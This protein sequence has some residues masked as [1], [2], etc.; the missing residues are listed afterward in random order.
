MSFVKACGDSNQLPRWGRHRSR[1]APLPSPS[2]PLDPVDAPARAGADP[3]PAH[4]RC[5]KQTPR[6]PADIRAGDLNRPTT[7]T[8]RGADT[9]VWIAPG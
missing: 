9:R 8:T 2:S 1:I 5:V 6:S 3:S 7:T 4:R